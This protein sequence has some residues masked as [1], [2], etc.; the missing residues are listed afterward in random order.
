MSSK[1]ND[2][3]WIPSSD[4]Y[5]IIQ[6]VDDVK[7]RFIDDQS[8][9]TLAIGLFGV[10]G[11]IEAKK[12]QSAIQET[13]ILGNEMFPTRAKLTKNLITHA[14]Y[15]NI[16]NINAKPAS[17]TLNLAIKVDDLDQYMKNTDSGDQEFIFSKDCPIYIV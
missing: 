3:S 15:H 4:I 9:T 17:I 5:N 10:L 7:A 6:M 16:T 8:E 14:A 12:I 13:Y 11:D 1:N 2:N